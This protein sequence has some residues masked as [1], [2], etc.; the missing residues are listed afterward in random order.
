MHWLLRFIITAIVMYA[1]AAYVPGFHMTGWTAA[2]IAA[3]IFGLVNAIIGPILRLIS[4][5]LTIITIG[6]FSIVV[7]W[8]LFALAVW[9]SPGFSVTGHP[10]P[11]WES[12][13]VGAIIMM[14][15]SMIVTA[16]M[17]R[18]RTDV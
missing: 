2:I 4:L 11:A 13:L 7:N 18:A 17:G 9:L 8:I 6:L 5:P 14:I 16:P 10:W 1:I 12:T 3:L 15:V